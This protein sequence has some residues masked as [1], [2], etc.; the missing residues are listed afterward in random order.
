MAFGHA[1]GAGRV[2][3]SLN[4]TVPCDLRGP[5]P[6]QLQILGLLAEG[7]TNAHR[8]CPEPHPARHGH[9]AARSCPR[10]AHGGVDM[11]EGQTGSVATPAARSKASQTAVL[12][13]V[14]AEGERLRIRIRAVSSRPVEG[15]TSRPLP[16]TNRGPRSR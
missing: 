6:L 9:P 4:A 10:L 1:G 8:R 11:L 7:W 5:A 3:R 2:G 16:E 14:T 12:D 15:S 13:P